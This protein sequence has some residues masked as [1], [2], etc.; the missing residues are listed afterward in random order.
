MK[1]FDPALWAKQV[2]ELR[3]TPEGVEFHDFI[4]FWADTAEKMMSESENGLGIPDRHD[5]A[6]V[7]IGPV[8]AIRDSFTLAQK[9]LGSP[10]PVYFAQMLALLCV[11]WYWRDSLFQGLT[12]IEKYIARVALDAK[13][14][15]LG[16]D[17]ADEK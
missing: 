5:L 9:T 6:L 11:F 13:L 12:S 17:A 10:E 2:S 3:E 14:A 15:Q 4:E 7:T 16:Q 1:A 8:Q